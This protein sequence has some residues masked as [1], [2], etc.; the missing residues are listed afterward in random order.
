MSAWF[1]SRGRF[2]DALRLIARLEKQ[3]ELLTDRNAVLSGQQ[4]L[5]A[6]PVV[7]A[8]VVSEAETVSERRDE[9]PVG[10]R[11]SRQEMLNKVADH[12]AK[13]PLGPI[14]VRS[15]RKHG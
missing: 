6:A 12:L 5:F 11:L 15:V 4:P 9:K 14:A 7:A 2:E 1:V 10:R 3:V 13:R 8:A